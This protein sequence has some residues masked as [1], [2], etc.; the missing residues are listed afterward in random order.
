[1][2][3]CDSTTADPPVVISGCVADPLAV[4]SVEA[5][6]AWTP[7]DMKAEVD[8]Q[9]AAGPI[10]GYVCP[11]TLASIKQLHDLNP[12]PVAGASMLALDESMAPGVIRYD[13]GERQRALSLQIVHYFE[14]EG[15]KK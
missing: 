3:R 4:V 7:E 5:F 6:A 2:D 14:P 10:C 11:A 13:H 12:D 9:A 1:M 8:R 15:G